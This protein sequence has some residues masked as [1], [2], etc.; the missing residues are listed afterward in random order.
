[1]YAFIARQYFDQ[2]WYLAHFIY[3]VDPTHWVWLSRVDDVLL[4]TSHIE[5]GRLPLPK[6]VLEFLFDFCLYRQNGNYSRD[7]RDRPIGVVLYSSS[8]CWWLSNNL[9]PRII[10]FEFCWILGWTVMT[11]WIE[12][13]FGTVVILSQLGLLINCVK[14]S[15]CPPPK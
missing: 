8:K 13:G 7:P 14:G 1:M 5:W 15:G 3:N 10:K 2:L 4:H 9:R 12:L 11:E 6:M